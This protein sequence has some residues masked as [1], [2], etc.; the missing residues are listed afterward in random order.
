MDFGDL[1]LRSS[2]SGRSMPLPG[3]MLDTLIRMV[4]VWIIR[5]SLTVQLSLAAFHP[6]PLRQGLSCRFFG[7]TIS[8]KTDRK[9]RYPLLVTILILIIVHQRMARLS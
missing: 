7:K 4:V 3:S 2:V 1:L 8:V 5:S 9:N 6:H